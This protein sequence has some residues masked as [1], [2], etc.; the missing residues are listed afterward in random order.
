MGEFE[1]ILNR[2]GYFKGGLKKIEIARE[3]GQAID[4]TNNHSASFV[5]FIEALLESVT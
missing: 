3:L 1:R 5:A 4:T 2:A